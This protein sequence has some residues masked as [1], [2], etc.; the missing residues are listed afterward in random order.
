M[1]YVVEDT[2]GGIPEDRKPLLF[3]WFD[4]PDMLSDVVEFDLSVAHRLAGKIGGN[5]HWDST[6]TKRTRMEF[7]FPVR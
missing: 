2:G 6:Y 4:K 5:L 3:T 7:V 1:T